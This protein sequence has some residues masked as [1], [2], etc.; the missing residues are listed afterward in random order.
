MPQPVRQTSQQQP[1]QRQIVYSY[2]SVPTIERFSESN[3]FVR[4]L[5]GPFGSGKSS[6]CV[7][8]GIQR[9]MMQSPGHDGI[10]Y[11]RGAVIRN[12]YQQ[13]TDTSL[14][15]FL[16]WVPERA[17]GSYHKTEHIYTI[18]KLPGCHVEIFF[19]ALDRPDQVDNLLSL[20]LTW[21]WVN[22]AREVPWSIIKALMGRVRR[23]PAKKDGG[24]SWGGIFMDTN[25][26]DDDSWW[27]KLFEVQR[28][29]SA[30][31]FR[32]PGG[33]SGQAE[34]LPNLEP[35]YYQNLID[36]G[37]DESDAKVYVHGEYGFFRD[38]KPI[39]PEYQDSFHC[40]AEVLEAV[41]DVGITLGW[42]FGLTP[43]CAFLQL[44]PSGRVQV[45]D[46]LL[47]EEHGKMGIRG[48]ARDV[49]KPHIEEHY[50]DW[51]TKGIMFGWGDPAGSAMS[52]TDETT[53][54]Q[55]LNTQVFNDMGIVSAPA[56]T[57]AFIPRKDGVS[58]LLIAP[59]DDG[60]MFLLSPKCRVL[61]KALMGGYHYDRLRVT[62]DAKYRDVPAKNAYSHIAEAM[63][64]AAMMIMPRSYEP[65]S[66][67]TKA[68]ADWAHVRTG[69][70]DEDYLTY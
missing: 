59:R 13:L 41:P 32:Q 69:Y 40:S 23:F 48:F 66:I 37:M 16:S 26:P 56:G 6:G 57:N 34:N 54:Y 20:E 4:G 1:K 15:T 70:R 61:R 38:A 43:A 68:A 7:L 19:R 53:C 52:Q 62:G 12:T 31:L 60:P 39:F 64:Y 17:F 8:E 2:E 36:S 30:A 50:K 11:S 47:V 10:R 45:I 58:K 24:C 18:T 28:P 9:S 67:P 65:T 49:V 46:E 22:E 27:Y 3:L 14:R 51:V 25:P 63:M 55:V 44:L 21:A 35:D 33:L 5:M 42:D 29:K